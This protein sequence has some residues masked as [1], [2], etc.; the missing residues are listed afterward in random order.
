MN[1][2]YRAIGF[3]AAAGALVAACA[4]AAHQSVYQGDGGDGVGSSGV[5]SSGVGSSTGGL[6]GDSALNLT[7]ASSGG[8]GRAARAQRCDDS[9]THCSCFN[10]ASIGQPGCS[11]C[12]AAGN[13]GDT[14]SSFVDYLNA[15]SSASI[16]S[17]TTKP[18]LTADFLAKYDVLIIQG[19][20]D[21]CSGKTGSPPW[22]ITGNLWSFSSTEIAA[23]KTWV[24][25]GGGLITLSGFVS[26]T[27]EVQPLNALVEAV[28]NNDISYGTADVHGQDLGGQTFCLGESDPL[29]GWTTTLPG[30][31][32]DPI[33]QGITD[34]GAFHGRPITVVAGSKAV[35]DNQDTTTVY[36]AHEDVGMGHVF[37]FFDEWVTYTSQWPGGTAGSVCASGCQPDAMAGAVYQV[38]QFWENAV[39]YAAQATMCPVFKII[40]L[41]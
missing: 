26:D 39:N 41:M 27:T 23:V 34:I 11:G 28:T 4:T 40:T 1:D 19:L 25:A 16:D 21:G 12:E 33:T 17:Y 29:T 5:G 32:P 36:A 14:T 18:A 7:G 9:G 2:K 13:G 22:S 38:P 30:G 35:I 37:T 3:L 24:A 10:I 6:T 20:Y 15:H 31:G 8:D